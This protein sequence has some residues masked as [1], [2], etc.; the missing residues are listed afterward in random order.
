MLS[1]VDGA[2]SLLRHPSANLISIVTGNEVVFTK[3]GWFHPQRLGGT[4]FAAVRDNF[5]GLE[6]HQFNFAEMNDF[7]LGAT[8]T[9]QHEF[10][11]TGS[12]RNVGEFQIPKICERLIR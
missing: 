12:G 6:D 1:V 5:H 10:A 7:L 2:S 9:M 4:S 11:D 3:D 8:R